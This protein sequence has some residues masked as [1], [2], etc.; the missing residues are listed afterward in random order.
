MKKQVPCQPKLCP[1]SVVS[2]G[3]VLAF[4]SKL[5]CALRARRPT[6]PLPCHQSSRCRQACDKSLLDLGIQTI[7]LYY[8]HRVDK[9]VPIEDTVRAM[10]VRQ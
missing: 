1:H 9:K 10:A 8:Q 5:S 7:D 2:V 4:G 6:H 3:C